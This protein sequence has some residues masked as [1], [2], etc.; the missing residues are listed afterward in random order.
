MKKIK[1]VINKIRY[2]LNYD[3]DGRMNVILECQNKNIKQVETLKNQLDVL[4]KQ[5]Y[6]VSNDINNISKIFNYTNP[7]MLQLNNFSKSSRTKILICGFYGAVNLGDELMLETI[8]DELEKLGEFDITI[9]LCDNKYVDITKYKKY[10][11]IHYPTKI[12]DFNILANYYDCL[13]FGGGALLDDYNYDNKTN[14]S[15]GNILI[16]LSMRFIT[17][18]KK[19]IL[20]GLST[21][22]KLENKEFI[23]KLNYITKH[24][25]YFSLRDT[26]SLEVLRKNNIDVTNVKIVDDIVLA[27]DTLKNFELN[28][29][30]IDSIGMIYICND[31]TYPKIKKYTM[32]TIEYFEKYNKNYEITLIPFYSYKNNDINYYKKLQ[33]EINNKN[34]V[35]SN[36]PENY[37]D[38]L[39]ILNNQKFIISM[40]YHGTLIANII[41]KR[42]LS[43]DYNVHR[44]YYNKLN[45]IYNKYNFE[46][47][48]LSFSKENIRENLI[49]LFGKNKKSNNENY[50]DIMI[51]AKEELKEAL[52]IVD[53]W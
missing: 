7:E 41:K 48:R 8:L 17:F 51:K 18:D 42:V 3:F 40:R 50:A 26:N 39:K 46:K 45:Y 13:I 35:I 52:K 4:K 36:M 33:M 44:H 12:M 38:L 49:L 14:L 11:F 10:N 16:N 24:A 23:E 27:S 47:N 21:N 19:T 53:R 37:A 43:V 31:K 30:D 15:L 5:L 32:D 34:I 25:T 1:R 20:Y 9:M 29:S 6:E 28:N 22:D 2:L